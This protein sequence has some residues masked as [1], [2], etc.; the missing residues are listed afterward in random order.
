MT[1]KFIIVLGKHVI[2]ESVTQDKCYRTWINI[3]ELTFIT[4]YLDIIDVKSDEVIKSTIAYEK[5]NMIL[6]KIPVMVKSILC[7]LTQH[8]EIQTKHYPYDQGGVFIVN[9]IKR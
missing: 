9:E 4:Q 1:Y 2:N 8:P 3:E 5:E 7:N 6:G